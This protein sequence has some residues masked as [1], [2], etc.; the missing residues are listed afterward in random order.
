MEL[1]FFAVDSKVREESN[2]KQ[3]RD[4]VFRELRQALIQM[5]RK[6]KRTLRG[7]DGKETLFSQF[8]M[9]SQA[10][11]LVEALR[12]TYGIVCSVTDMLRTAHEYGFNADQIAVLM[13][14]FNELGMLL[15]FPNVQGCEDVVIL[16]TQLLIDTAA[17]VLRQGGVHGTQVKEPKEDGGIHVEWD[18]QDAKRGLFPVNRLEHV[19]QHETK[20][21]QFAA[22]QAAL[23]KAFKA[24]FTHLHFVFPIMRGWRPYYFVPA[25]LPPRPH[26]SAEGPGAIEDAEIPPSMRWIVHR[27]KSRGHSKVEVWDFKLN[28]QKQDFLPT[29][30]F[31]S[32]MCAIAME[33]SPRLSE[34]QIDL[35]HEEVDLSFQGHFMHAKINGLEIHVH[36]IN[37]H[38]SGSPNRYY[39]SGRFWYKTFVKCAHA[40]QKRHRNLRFEVLPRNASQAGA[41]SMLKIVLNGGG[42]DTVISDKDECVRA[43]M[44]T[45]AYQCTATC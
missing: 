34:S 11:K 19:W 38:D 12:G 22:G 8:K 44:S 24:V 37:Y 15:Y 29:H 5:E 4:P 36:T 13:P 17:S 39:N 1:W 9:P 18:V 43:C 25:L 42:D 10:V 23:L 40:L 27:L 32:L 7:L 28:F 21:G 16:D 30:L 41:S 14:V 20:Y 26:Q 33:I 3:P 31:H 35:Y 45:H 6:D 2:P